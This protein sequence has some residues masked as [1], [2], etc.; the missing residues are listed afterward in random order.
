MINSTFSADGI[1][2]SKEVFGPRKSFLPE[3]AVS[4]NRF[5]TVWP[6]WAIFE[7]FWRQIF[8]QKLPENL[9]I[10]VAFWKT[11]FL[12]KNYCDYFTAHFGHTVSLKCFFILKK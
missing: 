5:K 6:D 10:L 7:S 1:V 4:K 11:S 9:L 8:L 2:R 3:A 12:S